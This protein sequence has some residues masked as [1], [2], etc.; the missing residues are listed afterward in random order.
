MASALYGV[1]PIDPIS[2]VGALLI[3]GLIVLAASCQ[4]VLQAMNVEVA[5]VLKDE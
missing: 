4:P 2:F 5:T 1:R 3:A